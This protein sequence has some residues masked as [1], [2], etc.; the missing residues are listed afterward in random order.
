M[1]KSMIPTESDLRIALGNESF[2]LWMEIVSFV[3]SV[4]SNPEPEW[5][6]PGAKHGWSFRLKDKKRVIVYFL[7]R[8]QYFMVAFNFGEIAFERIMNSDISRKIKTELS[9]AKQ[10]PEGRGIRIEVRDNNDLTDVKKLIEI[11]LAK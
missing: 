8:E 9:E 7:P 1:D 5:K 11:K 10:Y 4:Y 6:F 2:S 3:K